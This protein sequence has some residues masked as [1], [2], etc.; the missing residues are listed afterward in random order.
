MAARHTQGQG[1]MTKPTEEINVSFTY[2]RRG[3]AGDNGRPRRHELEE[4]ELQEKA[5]PPLPPHSRFVNVQSANQHPS[6][7]YVSWASG[8]EGGSIDGDAWLE[9]VLA[10]VFQSV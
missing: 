5:P 3:R 1:K 4:S 2:L 7:H 6:C 8:G 9:S 10:L